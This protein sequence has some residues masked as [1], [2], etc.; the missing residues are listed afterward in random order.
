MDLLRLLNG[1][2]TASLPRAAWT[3]QAHLRAGQAEVL[4]ARSLTEDPALAARLAL[5]AMR[6]RIRLLND[7]HGVTNGPDGG[8]HETLTWFY[9]SEISAFLDELPVDAARLTR[10]DLADLATMLERSE[11]A[12]SDAP[13]RRYSAAELAAP[14]ARQRIIAP[15]PTRA[16]KLPVG[17]AA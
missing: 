1:Y 5:D 17:A 10:R 15:A 3:H 6:R 14:E 4:A 12:R 13:L 8:Y 2:A 7:A 9:V 11:L 16:P